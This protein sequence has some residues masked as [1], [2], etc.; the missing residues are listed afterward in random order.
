VSEKA[1]EEVPLTDPWLS[2][3]E[4]LMTLIIWGKPK[5]CHDV[6]FCWGW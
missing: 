4:L 2:L 1:R 5:G 6:S 3:F